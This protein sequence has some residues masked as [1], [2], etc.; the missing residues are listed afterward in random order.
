L[1]FEAKNGRALEGRDI[2]LRDERDQVTG[3]PSTV[4]VRSTVIFLKKPVN[5]GISPSAIFVA[6]RVG[7][8]EATIVVL[9]IQELCP[10]SSML[11]D[12][13]TIAAGA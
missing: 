2:Y 7:E 3:Q 5:S 11:T 4:V 10:E 6:P 1:R 12:E 8:E 9:S 13:A